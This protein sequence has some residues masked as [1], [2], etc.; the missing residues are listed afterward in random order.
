MFSRGFCGLACAWLGCG[1]GQSAAAP[2]NLCRVRAERPVARSPAACC[3]CREQRCVNQSFDPAWFY[4]A[5]CATYCLDSFHPSECVFFS[6][7]HLPF[8]YSS[9]F[10]QHRAL[11]QF[12]ETRYSNAFHQPLRDS[13]ITLQLLILVSCIT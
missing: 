10:I 13:A 11:I 9:G 6:T 3:F 2:V 4:Y 12:L 8:Y 5:V 1:C 7:S